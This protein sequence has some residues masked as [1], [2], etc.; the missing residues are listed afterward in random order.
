MLRGAFGAAGSED[1]SVASVPG[2]AWTS[3]GFG[4]QAGMT[5]T[6][7]WG[8]GGAAGA[9]VAMSRACGGAF[10]ET[11]S[12]QAAEPISAACRAGTG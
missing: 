3:T 7:G 8:D 4:C 2:V 11:S 9:G 5:W 1:A 6:T 12:P 10:E